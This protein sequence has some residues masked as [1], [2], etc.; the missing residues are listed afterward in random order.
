MRVAG[1]GDVVVRVTSGVLRLR[2]VVGRPGKCARRTS[3]DESAFGGLEVEGEGMQ[4]MVL[5][6]KHALRG[7]SMVGRRR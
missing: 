5:L 3:V 7:R 4:L 2:H 6:I 1:L